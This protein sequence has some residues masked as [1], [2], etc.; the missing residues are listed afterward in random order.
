M[1]RTPRHCWRL[2]HIDSSLLLFAYEVNHALLLLLFLLSQAAA[3]L[4]ILV[5]LQCVFSPYAALIFIASLVSSFSFFVFCCI[6]CILP[7]Q[8][9]RGDADCVDAFACAL[10]TLQR[11]AFDSL[12]RRP[13]AEISVNAILLQEISAV[14]RPTHLSASQSM[15][16][17]K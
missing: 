8:R 2:Q 13:D 17:C 1:R 11:R 5:V 7:M 16:M 12:N 9:H 10:S 3:A 6:C 15:R 4:L 14:A